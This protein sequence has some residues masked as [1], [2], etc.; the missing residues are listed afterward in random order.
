M[1]CL[2]KAKEYSLAYYLPIAGGRIR[3]FKTSPRVLEFWE[4]QSVSSRNWTLV[5][6]SISYNDNRYTS[7]HLYA[8]N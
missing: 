4:E 2:T 8:Y 3:G 1:G 7:N 6:V 5:T